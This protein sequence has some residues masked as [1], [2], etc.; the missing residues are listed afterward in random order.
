MDLYELIAS[1]FWPL[2]ALILGIFYK[3]TIDQRKTVTLN[4]LPGVEVR[5]GE[6]EAHGDI[7][8]LIEEL[9]NVYNRALKKEHQVFF[10]KL[11]KYDRD[12]TV[13]AV[14]PK[15]DRNNKEH[16][17]MLRALRGLGMIKPETGG[18]WSADKIIVITKFGRK[19][20]KFLK[21]TKD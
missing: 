6:K 18:S 7:G 9:Y 16:I 13:G 15:F 20:A 11:L 14:I 3:K 12:V 21:E 10:V 17:G 8:E 2:V 5:L 19:F 1:S 4:L